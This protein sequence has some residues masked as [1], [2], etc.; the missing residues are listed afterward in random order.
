M[1]IKINYT[2]SDV[3]VSTSVSPVY[4]FV[5]YGPVTSS[6]AVWGGITGTLSNQ[7]D[8][9]TALDGKFDDPTGDTTQ[10]IA[11][12]G[13]LVAFPIA[14][15]AGTLVREVRNITG[16][17][18]TKGTVVYINGASGNK[19]TVTKAI[20]TGDSTSAQT[21]GIVQADITN[22]SNGYVVAVGDIDGLNT[23]AFADGAQLYL[24]ATTAGA[25]T[26]VKQY[27]PNHLVYIGVITRSHPTQGRI[28][29]R[30]QNG[31]E[32]DEIHNVAAQTPSNNDALIYES[33]TSLWKNKTIATA[34]GYTPVPTTRTLTINGTAYDLSADRSWTIAGLSDGDKG[35]ITVSSSGATWTID[36]GVIG[37]AKLSA[38][39]TPSS[40]TYLRGDNTWATVSG[41]G[42]TIYSGDGTL[43]GN[44]VV[45][46][47]TNSLTFTGTS[48]ALTVADFVKT[49]DASTYLRVANTNGGGQSEVGLYL[50]SN[51][52]VCAIANFPTTAGNAS[53]TYFTN[54]SANGMRFWNYTN[55]SNAHISFASTTSN[56]ER[57]RLTTSGRL[58]LGTT[59]ESTFI[60][61]AV[62]SDAR[63]NGVRIGK[64]GG[65]VSSNTAV[66][67]SSL[68]SNTT[69][70]DNCAFGSSA[71]GS[72]TTGLFCSAF[73]SGALYS[74][75]TGT[76]NSAFGYVSLYSS[77]G[78]RN[79]AFG[80]ASLF[81]LSSGNDNTALGNNAG[82]Y[83]AGGATANTTTGTSIFIGS[84]TKAL[85]DNQTNQI[86]IGYNETGLGSN[87][88]I[89]GNSSTITTAL[90]GR[91][92]LGTTTDSGSYQL[93]V[94]GTA[95][96][97]GASSGS[98]GYSLVVTDTNSTIGATLSLTY[99]GTTS[100]F[101]QSRTAGARFYSSNSK[102]FLAFGYTSGNVVVGGNETSYGTD[103][104]NIVNINSTTTDG[105]GITLDDL[106]NTTAVGA[107]INYRAGAKIC[108]S[109]RWTINSGYNNTGLRF[110][111]NNN[112]GTLTEAFRVTETQN[113]LVGSTTNIPSAILAADSTTKG[114]RPPAMTTTQKNAISSPAAGLQVY[115]TTL[116]QMSY[117]N[118]TTWVNF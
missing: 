111:V 118:G 39:G 56:T 27:A 46:L 76:H 14:G 72:L 94:N 54:T 74:F 26:D 40:T 107:G 34:L 66:G 108:G 11:G 97:S 48:T 104:L 117:Y 42:T 55:S 91:L 7:T 19:P 13:S 116:N 90:R 68:N 15:Q 92:L 93:D 1:V 63:I 71:A 10:Y 65:S 20:A 105:V 80:S 96:V 70:F 47:G 103:K 78:S 43:A 31:Y 17:T 88:T 60:F 6:G 57:M 86:V 62:G 112:A 28:E 81:S 115:D 101:F 16:A 85:A 83:I 77:V 110:F 102:E 4:V 98:T 36:N 114:F 45:T 3:Y 18:L 8:L 61:D 113:V 5:N 106:G 109:I 30:I 41:G 38:T 29:V 51:S 84:D 21:F 25:Y 73:G 87:T 89:I 33:S 9:Q 12:D 49:N 44:R 52:G 35:D 23:S 37:V 64:G 75:I 2:S 58:L 24:S 79:S 53:S 59:T 50:Q 82:R 100:I 22:N 69:G 32:L 99:I 95:R 67:S